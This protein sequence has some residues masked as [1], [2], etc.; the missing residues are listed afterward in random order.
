MRTKPSPAIL[1]LVLAACGE[2]WPEPAPVDTG[3]FLAEHEEWRAYR[4]G[5]LVT[6]PGGA[7]LWMGLWDLPQGASPFGSDG[8]LAIRLPEV[9]SPALAGVLVREGQTVT[10]EPAEGADIRIRTTA[11]DS[12]EVVETPVTEA[13]VLGN[14]RSGDPTM[15][16]LGSLGM[17]IHAEPGTDRLWLRAWDEDSP[18][19]ETFRLP[20]YYPVSED[21][22]VA[23]RFVPYDDPEMLSVP[24]VRGGTVEYRVP[25]ELEF[26][27][28][29]R[30]YTL[31]AT[32]GENSS[33]FFVMMWDSTATVN[34]Y[35]AGRYLRV[36][37]P[38]E[39][40]WTEIDFNRAYNAPCV[41]TP[42]SV[43]AIPPRANWL[44]MHVTA[45][46]QRPDPPRY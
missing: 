1:A 38:D 42:H 43:C 23:A 5:R 12:D 39:S 34:T 21:W 10:L 46:E 31:Q 9:D 19:R 25:G 14:D 30:E 37:L 8:D 44:A 26:R 6:P 36:A 11:D 15:L 22:R 27:H 45:G 17:R 2:A 41:F 29:G 28:R 20:P 7:V 13:T 16:V 35:Q 32:A 33:S 4:E 3:T 40:G 18:E 24:D